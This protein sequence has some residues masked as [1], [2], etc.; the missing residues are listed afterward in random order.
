VVSGRPLLR[1][2]RGDSG[3]LGHER[4][5]AVYLILLTIQ[6]RLMYSRICLIIRRPKPSPDRLAD[7]RTGG[8]E[9]LQRPHNANERSMSR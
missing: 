5:R 4:L 1:D 3:G 2:R 6:R 9:E 8:D 7:L